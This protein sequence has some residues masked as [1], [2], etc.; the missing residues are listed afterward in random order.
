MVSSDTNKI[1]DIIS[2]ILEYWGVFSHIVE[3]VEK[4]ECIYTKPM[5]IQVTFLKN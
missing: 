2:V 4:E 5:K 3:K 1:V